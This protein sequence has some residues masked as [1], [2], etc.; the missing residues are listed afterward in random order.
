MSDGRRLDLRAETGRPRLAVPDHTSLGRPAAI[1]GQDEIHGDEL[2]LI[3][4]W[5]SSARKPDALDNAAGTVVRQ[6]PKWATRDGQPRYSDLA[7]ETTLTLGLVFSLLLRQTEGFVTSVLK[8]IGLDL[9]VPDHA[10][11]SRRAGIVKLTELGA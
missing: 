11:L 2:A 6:A 3:R 8:P 9:A 10:T 1:I 4:S 5:P 7:I